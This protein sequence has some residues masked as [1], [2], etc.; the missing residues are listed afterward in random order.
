MTLSISVKPSG[1]HPFGGRTV[2]HFT[3]ALN[4]KEFGWRPYS[5]AMDLLGQCDYL[6]GDAI[7]R[8]AAELAL[9]V[10]GGPAS[11]SLRTP[12]AELHCPN[13]VDPRMLALAIRRE[14]SDLGWHVGEPT[15]ATWNIIWLV[16]P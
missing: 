11:V 6:I 2:M 3:E 1:L 8:R 10:A 9:V 4:V 15:E 14:L 5:V 13:D 16:M 7:T 12:H